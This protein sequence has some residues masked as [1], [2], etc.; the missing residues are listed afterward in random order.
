M[1]D[2]EAFIYRIWQKPNIKISFK[3]FTLRTTSGN[4]R[5]SKYHHYHRNVKIEE[6]NPVRLL[7]AGRRFIPND[8]IIY[9]QPD[10]VF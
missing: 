2:L 5:L 3:L 6:A 4:I 10:E 9:F 1:Q 8:E 7:H